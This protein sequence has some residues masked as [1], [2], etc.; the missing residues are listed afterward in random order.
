MTNFFLSIVGSHHSTTK[1]R[2]DRNAQAL[3]LFP[4]V[5]YGME[6]RHYSHLF[7]TQIQHGKVT[8]VFRSCEDFFPHTPKVGT[9]DLLVK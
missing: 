7:Q 8:V 3:Q 2:K 1:I 4:I 9:P 6:P 5:T